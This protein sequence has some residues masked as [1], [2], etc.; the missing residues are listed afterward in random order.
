[1]PKLPVS[2]QEISYHFEAG[3]TA[4]CPGRKMSGLRPP[5]S[6]M[7]LFCEETY[8]DFTASCFG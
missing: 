8:F 2:R 7:W 4:T 1:V 5:F 6:K 3:I